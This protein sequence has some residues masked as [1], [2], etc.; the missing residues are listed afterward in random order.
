M[1]I[2]TQGTT[3]I[4]WT[5]DDG[6][7]NTATQTQNVIINDTTPPVPDVAILPDIISECEITTLT[8][9]TATDNCVGNIM[10]TTDVSLP[11]NNQALTLVTWTYDDGNGNTVSQT[12][13]VYYFPIDNTVTQSGNTLTAT[14]S[15]NYTYQWGDCSN[16]F[17]PINGETG[18]SFTPTVS[19]N[20]AVIISNGNCSVTSDCINVT[21][22][23]INGESL[24]QLKVYPN[25]TN[26]K[27]T[28]DFG[29]TLNN[30]KVEIINV[31]GQTISDRTFKNRQVIHLNLNVSKGVYYLKVTKNN[32]GS[33][34]V[35]VI[36]Q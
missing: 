16:G 12:Q 8:P 9:P 19:G 17:I 20:Y 35:R 36:K 22:S 7:G 29:K 28:L 30:V 10:A 21:I 5:Y 32:N 33:K 31:I 6:N 15:G 4:T 13:A 26:N 27:I 1:P 3:V 11:I 34:I 18:Q 25:P 23:T 24:S 2:T 14:A